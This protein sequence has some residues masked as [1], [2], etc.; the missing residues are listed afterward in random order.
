MYI[1]INLLG[2]EQAAFN[3]VLKQSTEI[4]KKMKS[5]QLS[6]DA[7]SQKRVKTFLKSL[8]ADDTKAPQKLLN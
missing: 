2:F 1:C 8:N 6:H 4:N 7:W 3:P 5:K